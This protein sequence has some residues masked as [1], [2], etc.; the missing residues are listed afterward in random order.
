MHFLSDRKVFFIF[1]FKIKIKSFLGL[2]HP[3]VLGVAFF[4]WL[5][6]CILYRFEMAFVHIVLAFTFQVASQSMSKVFTLMLASSPKLTVLFC[7]YKCL[8][9][10]CY[11]LVL[12]LLLIRIGFGLNLTSF[13]GCLRLILHALTCFI[14]SFEPFKTRSNKFFVYPLIKL[15]EI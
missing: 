5:L 12:S 6:I 10:M 2:L 8:P 11:T 15:L 4:V 9:P 1:I 7:F 14:R 13:W 3:S